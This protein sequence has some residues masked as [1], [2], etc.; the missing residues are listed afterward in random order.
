MHHVVVRWIG[1]THSD[2][3]HPGSN[4]NRTAVVPPIRTASSCV[5][6]GVRA[7]ESKSRVSTTAIA[8]SSRRSTLGSSRSSGS[9]IANQANGGQAESYSVG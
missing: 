4:A 2:H 7:G 8:A 6:S 3:R 5:F 9:E 1:L